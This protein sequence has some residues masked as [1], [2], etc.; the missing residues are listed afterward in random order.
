MIDTEAFL[1]A[2]ALVARQVGIMARRLQGQVKNEG[3]DIGDTSHMSDY[4]RRQSE[5]KTAIDEISQDMIITALLP[6]LPLDTTVLDGEEETPGKALMPVTKGE[7]VLVLDPIDGTL[8]YLEDAHT[9]SVNIGLFGGGHV[10]AALLYYP[11]LD[12][13]YFTDGK[14]AYE[15]PDFAARGLATRRPVGFAAQPA[16]PKKIYVYSD[17]KED[18]AVAL[19]AAGYTVVRSFRGQGKNDNTTGG[20]LAG[21]VAM[22]V[23]DVIAVRD[24]MH[25]AIL[26]VNLPGSL[27]DWQGKPVLWPLLGGAMP[28][29][30]I[31]AWPVPDDVKDILARYS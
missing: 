28:K 1:T 24:V 16:D 19:R 21:A 10:V 12:V 23:L 2:A 6:H 11:A 20:I 18:V 15:A 13:A 27:C 7:Y 30:V 3:K 31:S 17:V 22:A 4:A 14:T 26:T 9:Y 29:T 8:P 5:A 25:V